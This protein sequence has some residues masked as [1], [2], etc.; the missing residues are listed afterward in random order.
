MT[1][2]STVNNA[3]I[4]VSPMNRQ[5]TLLLMRHAKSD[6]PDGVPDHDRPLAPR[7]IR[8]AG[9]A[10]NWL[11]AN[12]PAIDGVLCSTATRRDTCWSSCITRSFRTLYEVRPP[13]T[14]A[15]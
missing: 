5:R 3:L 14:V 1:S 12:A 7:G 9:L 13:T 10:G 15:A 4:N 6:S 2:G 8:Q 11:R